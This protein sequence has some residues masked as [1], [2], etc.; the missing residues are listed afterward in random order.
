[1]IVFGCSPS[2]GSSVLVRTLDRHSQIVAGPETAIF[3][4]LSLMQNWN[5][6]KASIY[7]KTFL[8]LRDHGWHRYRGV[9]LTD[10][11]YPWDKSMLEN[12][13]DSSPDFISFINSLEK[14]ILEKYSSS[15]WIE[16]TPSNVYSFGWLRK[17][18]PNVRFILMLRNPYDTIASL[19]NRG[20]SIPYAVGS[21]LL[22]TS[23]GY[24]GNHNDIHYIRYE[25]LVASPKTEILKINK[26]IGV[27]FDEAMLTSDGE[28]ITMD[29]WLQSETEIIGKKSI[30]RFSTI[31]IKIQEEIISCVHHTYTSPEF[32]LEEMKWCYKHIKEICADWQY[33]Y[34]I[35]QDKSKN[36]K[37]AKTYIQEALI[38]TAKLYPT[39][40]F[41]F[42]LR[43]K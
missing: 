19:Y 16:K 14:F 26:F 32:R 13:V 38:R 39:H 23:A 40:L 31:P 18:V 25:D 11:F 43:Y 20:Y 21:Y 12:F 29:G 41:N 30:D 33:E 35:P 2:V 5:T 3:S 27:N 15:H 42:P 17:H 7:K 6:Y 28:N 24:L 34:I 37:H 1:M 22:H 9:S 10:S 8:K 4:R 36:I